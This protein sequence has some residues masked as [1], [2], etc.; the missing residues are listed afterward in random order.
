MPIIIN[1]ERLRLSDEDYV[2]VIDI[3]PDLAHRLEELAEERSSSVEDLI[4]SLLERDK[5]KKQRMTLADLAEIAVSA[6]L[7]SAEPVD[8]S[9]RSREI[10]NTEY[11]DYLKRRRAI[12]PKR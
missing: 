11:A 2:M 5:P 8:T 4:R 1:D 10:L 3:S 7:A 12:A 6:G 9:E